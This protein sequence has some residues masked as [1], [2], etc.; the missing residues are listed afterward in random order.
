M[1]SID[2]ISVGGNTLQNIIR[3]GRVY[4]VIVL[5]SRHWKRFG[6]NFRRMF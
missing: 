3:V 1:W 4:I 2:Y 5:L 6:L